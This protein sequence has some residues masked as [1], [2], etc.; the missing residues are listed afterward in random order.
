MA[1]GKT[2]TAFTAST[3]AVGAAKSVT[4]TVTANGVPDTTTLVVTPT[5]ATRSRTGASERNAGHTH[6]TCVGDRNQAREVSG[7]AAPAAGAA[8]AAK[9]HARPAVCRKPAPSTS[10]CQPPAASHAGGDTRETLARR[11]YV[12]GTAVASRSHASACGC[13]GDGARRSASASGTVAGASAPS[14]PP[15]PLLSSARTAACRG[16]LS[17]VT[18]TIGSPVAASSPAA[19]ADTAG[20][21]QAPKRHCQTAGAAVAAGAGGCKVMVGGGGGGRWMTVAHKNLNRNSCSVQIPGNISVS[22]FR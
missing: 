7:G 18:S 13:A 16:G 20:P 1:L 21:R 2:A 12:K 22:F 15:P 6:I 4:I 10:S 5:A 8:S 3:T 19:A 9:T 14:P 11:W 17:H